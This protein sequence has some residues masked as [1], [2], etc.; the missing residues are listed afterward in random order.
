MVIT[1]TCPSCSSSFPVDPAKIPEGGVNARCSSCGDVFRVEKPGV[2]DGAGSLNCEDIGYDTEVAAFDA[3]LQQLDQYDF[4]DRENIFYFG[5]SLGGV[6]A[7]LLAAKHRPAGVVVYGTVFE[8]W[9]EYMQKV[10]RDQAYVRGDDWIRTEELSRR[11]QA[12]L[13]RLFVLR[14]SPEEM[15]DD[16]AIKE[17]L[18]NSILEFDGDSRFVGRHYRFW[19]ELNAANQAQAWREAGVH[20]LAIYGEYDLHAIGPEGARHIAELVNHYHPGKGKFVLL[21]GTEHA[22][23]RV[24]S[25]AEYVTMRQSGSF[26]SRFMAQ[27]FNPALVDTVVKWMDEVIRVEG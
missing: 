26:N 7:P 5:H 15:A 21:P 16:P 20:S 4:I 24:P 10:F 6:S 25:M 19:Q 22:F 2:G 23:T 11:A 12:F 3:A 9:Y 27:H 1:V 13:A 17:L 14:Q 8:S 18:D